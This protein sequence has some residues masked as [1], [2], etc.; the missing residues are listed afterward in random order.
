MAAVKSS[1]RGRQSKVSSRSRAYVC[2][3]L[4]LPAAYPSVGRGDAEVEGS[5][6]LVKGEP[7]ISLLI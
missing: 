1:G 3:R 2:R 4:A 6:A 5:A 7:D